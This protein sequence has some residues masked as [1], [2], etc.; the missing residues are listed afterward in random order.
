V[1]QTVLA[2]PARDWMHRA[3]ALVGTV[4]T[5][6]DTICGARAKELRTLIDTAN[7]A[8]MR[9][10][11]GREAWRKFFRSVMALEKSAQKDSN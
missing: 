4:R 9:Q 3:E 6:S 2:R 7:A 8:T 10:P 5:G 1:F 11:T